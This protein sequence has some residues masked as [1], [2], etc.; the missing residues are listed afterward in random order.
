ML[1]EREDRLGGILNQCIHNGFGL[2]VFK[3]EYT[4]PEYAYIYI[5]EFNELKI[6]YL[7]ETTVIKLVRVKDEFILYTSSLKRVYRN[8]LQ[9]QLLFLQVVM[10]EQEGQL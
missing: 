8:I 10:K 1:I 9:N 7:I 4:G 5:K 3:E 6:D 2:E